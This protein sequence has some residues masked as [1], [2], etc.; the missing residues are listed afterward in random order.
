MNFQT[1]YSINHSAP[2][3]TFQPTQRDYIYLKMKHGMTHLSH[4]MFHTPSSQGVFI[5]HTYNV[6]HI[7]HFSGG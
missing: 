3:P 6:R 5:H 1:P 4:T 7:Y 2:Y